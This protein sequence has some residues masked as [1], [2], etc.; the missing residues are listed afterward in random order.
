MKFV[1]IQYVSISMEICKMRINQIIMKKMTFLTRA[2]NYWIYEYF[3]FL[4]QIDSLMKKCKEGLLFQE[5]DLWVSWTFHQNKIF[6]SFLRTPDIVGSHKKF[7]TFLS[8][9]QKTY[10]TETFSEVSVLWITN[11]VGGGKKSKPFKQNSQKNIMR[12]NIIEYFLFL[13]KR[14][15]FNQPVKWVDQRI[16]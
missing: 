2:T 15:Q 1:K 10:W 7:L 11:K 9:A 5:F 16:W 8:K 14:I 4:K 6:Q 13:R 12:R 3:E